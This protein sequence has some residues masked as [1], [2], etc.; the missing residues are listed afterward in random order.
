[1]DDAIQNYTH[2]FDH[3]NQTKQSNETESSHGVQRITADD[4]LHK[5]QHCHDEIDAVNGVVKVVMRPQLDQV[6]DVIL[7][8]DDAARHDAHDRFDGEPDVQH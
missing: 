1:M 6:F 2:V 5:R 3:L 7:F 4:V 8:D